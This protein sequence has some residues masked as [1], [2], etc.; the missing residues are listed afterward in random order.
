MTIEPLTLSTLIISALVLAFLVVPMI[1][2][3]NRFL[4]GK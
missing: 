1:R 4:S 3:I 2:M